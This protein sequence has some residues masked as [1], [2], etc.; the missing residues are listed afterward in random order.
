MTPD[1]NE[2]WC[3]VLVI[4]STRVLYYSS[5][6]VQCDMI[7]PHGSPLGYQSPVP[8]SYHI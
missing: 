8:Y 6:V 1:T 5:T 7:G 2:Y 4:L 3:G